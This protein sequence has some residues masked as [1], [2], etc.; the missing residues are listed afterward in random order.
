M[1]VAHLPHMESLSALAFEALEACDDD[2]CETNDLDEP[3]EPCCPNGCEDCLLPCCSTPLALA[4][5]P[6]DHFLTGY[7][8][9]RPEWFVRTFDSTS[10]EGPF[11]P[12]RS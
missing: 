9:P 7:A 1:V 2:C 5:H 6:D 12:P 8:I 10:L 3:K 11:H 4:P